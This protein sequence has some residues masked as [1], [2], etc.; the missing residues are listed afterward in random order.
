MAIGEFKLLC[1]GIRGEAVGGGLG[2][3]GD[4]ALVLLL[5]PAA[6]VATGRCSAARPCLCT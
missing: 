4:V 5:L 6:V 1:G 2:L 3:G